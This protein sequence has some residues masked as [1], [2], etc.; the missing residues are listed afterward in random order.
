MDPELN[1]V[2]DDPCDPVEVFDNSTLEADV[3]KS[4]EITRS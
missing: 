4:Q 2:D 3:A 1:Y